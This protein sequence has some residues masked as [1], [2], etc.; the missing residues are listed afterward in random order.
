MLERLLGTGSFS[1]VCQALD[2]VTGERVRTV[3]ILQSEQCRPSYPSAEAGHVIHYITLSR[4][5]SAP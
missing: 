4:I 5:T 3:T 1:S 2:T